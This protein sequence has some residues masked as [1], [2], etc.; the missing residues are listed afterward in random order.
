MYMYLFVIKHASSISLSLS[1]KKIMHLILLLLLTCFAAIHAADVWID[2][3]NPDILNFSVEYLCITDSGL[4]TSASVR[5]AGGGYANNNGNNPKE[6]SFYGAL[7]GTRSGVMQPFTIRDFTYTGPAGVSAW[8]YLY[9]TVL[10][11]NVDYIQLQ[12]VTAG[13]E[14]ACAQ[15][16]APPS[17]WQNNYPGVP[18]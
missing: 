5:F 14:A 8:I 16:D 2:N 4:E 12:I 11:V 15:A 3:N 9:D 7:G 18:S 13:D 17:D 1:K 10:G 6:L